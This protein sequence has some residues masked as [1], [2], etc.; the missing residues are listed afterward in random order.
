MLRVQTKAR[1]LKP[2]LFGISKQIEESKVPFDL[3]LIQVV[4]F[5]LA[6]SNTFDGRYIKSLREKGRR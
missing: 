1:L 2:S 4:K 3:D 5:A 6:I